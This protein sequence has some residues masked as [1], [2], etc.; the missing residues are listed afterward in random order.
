MKRSIDTSLRKFSSVGFVKTDHDR[1]EEESVLREIIRIASNTGELS[2]AQIGQL[3]SIIARLD[4]IRTTFTNNLGFIAEF[5]ADYQEIQRKFIQLDTQCADLNKLL[6][7]LQY[8][9]QFPGTYDNCLRE[10]ARREAFSTQFSS[11]V[12]HINEHLMSIVQDEIKKENDFF[13]TYH[14]FIPRQLAPSVFPCS[15]VDFQPIGWEPLDLPAVS[16]LDS[17]SS[18]FDCSFLSSPL[19][20][21]PSPSASI[22]SSASNLLSS[23]S[24]LSSNAPAAPLSSPT[25]VPPLISPS[26]IPQ[27]ASRNDPQLQELQSKFVELELENKRLLVKCD[28]LVTELTRLEEASKAVLP[29]APLIDPPKS[30]LEL[31]LEKLEQENG[32]L[33][34]QNKQLETTNSKLVVQLR[35][36]SER[37]A[38]HVVHLKELQSKVEELNATNTQLNNEIALLRSKPTVNLEVYNTMKAKLE[39]NERTLNTW[40][41]T[42][43]SQNEK[44]AALEKTIPSSV[45][46]RDLS[47]LKEQLIQANQMEAT[48]RNKIESLEKQMANRPFEHPIA[49][50]IAERNQMINQMTTLGDNLKWYQQQYNQLMEQRN[51]LNVNCSCLGQCFQLLPNKFAVFKLQQDGIAVGVTNDVGRSRYMLSKDATP[52]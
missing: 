39:E 12:S 37:A 41:E 50:L 32:S 49:S 15:S 26:A 14:N 25:P 1:S 13:Q 30:Q 21:P 17:C 42:I 46:L 40:K 18:A 28:E 36:E 16:V 10:I 23:P 33:L 5:F 22:A 44:I 8:P 47:V 38:M 6:I 7:G 34:S 9:S 3:N 48:L 27:Y 4:N 45:M 20:A 29:V 31:K 11:L 19:F 52:S 43:H 2:D 24:L 51:Y 35:D